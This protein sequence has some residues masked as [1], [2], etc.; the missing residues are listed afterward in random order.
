M[1]KW[2]GGRE[3]EHKGIELADDPVL[4]PFRGSGQQKR[5]GHGVEPQRS[6]QN[7]LLRVDQQAGQLKL[8]IFRRAALANSF[9]WRLL[10]Q[11]V[12]QQ[13]VDELTQALVMRLTTAGPTPAA[14]V[15]APA[16]RSAAAIPPNRPLHRQDLQGLLIRGNKYVE[17]GSFDEAIVCFQKV[18]ASDPGN[19]EVRH[20][21][22][23]IFCRM[24][25]YEEG[26]EQLRLAIKAKKDFADAHHNL[27]SLLR[28][29]GRIRESEQ[30]LRHALKLKPTLVEA[31]VSLGATLYLLGRMD[32]SRGCLQKALRVAP[33]NVDALANL[34]QLSALEG[35]FEESE[36]WFK[37]TLAEDPN[38]WLAWSGLAALGKMSGD[39]WLRGAQAS[40]ESGL[41]VMNEA[42][43]RNAIGR[44]YDK[45][46]D[47]PQAFRSF[48]HSKELVK[49][50][51]VPYD[52]GAQTL[53]LEKLTK[54][55]SRGTLANFGSGASD[56]ALPILV[57]GVPRSGTSLVEQIIASHP[58]V[59]GAGE[60]E[61]WSQ[62]AAKRPGALLQEMPD[63]DATRRLAAE[64]LR[65][66]RER[67][68]KV[69]HV[70]DKSLFNAE[71]LGLIHRAFPK[72]RLVH[73]QRDPIDTCLSCYFQDFPP[74]LNFTL[75]LSDLA[76]FYRQRHELMEHWRRVLPSGAMLDVP[77]EG[78]ISDQEGWTRRILE[79][80][81]LPW[82]EA[83][84]AFDKTERSVLTASYWQVRQ[85]VYGTSVGRWH[86][87]EK[88]IGPL[89][90]LKDL[91]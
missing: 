51:A 76:H 1:F 79:F 53:R 21:L 49:T 73:V 27:G 41:P 82:D 71:Y 7:F 85:K 29:Q 40:A 58:M 60:V 52:R 70:V 2:L 5:K 59:G 46:G 15:R 14:P 56:S 30:P 13:V 42:S 24:G 91:R 18:L 37:R 17:S 38:A 12:E 35:R 90:G 16:A 54:F 68:G 47:F 33:R 31:Q 64:Y 44:Y 87:Y 26:E 45:A 84:L 86:H 65:V 61:F 74:S 80:L 50:A 3:A 28:S 88:F 36:T 66:L 72:A 89:L 4:Q 20:L 77:Y 9:K 75:D 8:N 83:C 32:E 69:A 67:S 11:G 22:G 34:G 78:L 81:G 48:R 62:A 19:A 6:L 63:E 23:V 25:R 39:T 55:Y 57:I 10:E 43:V